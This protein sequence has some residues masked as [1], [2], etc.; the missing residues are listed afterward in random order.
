M[1]KNKNRS[2]SHVDGFDSQVPIPT[3]LPS[4]VS[5]SA[6]ALN[7]NWRNMLIYLSQHPEKAGTFIADI[8][9]KFFN[10]DACPIKS[11]KIDFEKLPDTYRP[12]FT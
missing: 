12:V 8:R 6:E 10:V 4:T 2:M 7:A 11:P 1:N 5:D 3:I 9:E